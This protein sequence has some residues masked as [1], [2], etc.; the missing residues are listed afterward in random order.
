MHADR[1]RP[2][3]DAVQRRVLA[4]VQ[5]ACLLATEDPGRKMVG[6]LRPGRRWVLCGSVPRLAPPCPKQGPAAAQHRSTPA[7]EAQVPIEPLLPRH[8]LVD[9][10][11]PEQVVIDDTFHQVEDAEAHEDATHQ[12]LTRP[13]DVGPARRPPEDDQAKHD[14]DVSDRVEEPVPQRIDLEVFDAGR[15]ISG[16]RQHVMPLQDLVQ[17]DAVEKAAQAQSK[18]DA[19]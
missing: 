16:A 17:D 8:R 18:E 6:L 4:R 2:D 7:E 10:V 5:D 15:W 19:R 12:E 13:T 1:P 14:E 11:D 3:H 9:M